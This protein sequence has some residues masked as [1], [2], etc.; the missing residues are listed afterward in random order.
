MH[1]FM[2]IKSILMF[3]T[4]NFG[5]ILISQEKCLPPQFKNLSYSAVNLASLHRGASSRL[6]LLP[7]GRLLWDR[8]LNLSGQNTLYSVMSQY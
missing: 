1:G 8:A 7:E 3:R 4:R 2:N 6:K 5:I